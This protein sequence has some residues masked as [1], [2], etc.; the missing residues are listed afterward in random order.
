MSVTIQNI[1]IPCYLLSNKLPV[2]LVFGYLTLKIKKKN[3][4][5]LYLPNGTNE[6]QKIPL[7]S[8]IT[9]KIK[10]WVLGEKNY[11]FTIDITNFI[12]MLKNIDWIRADLGV[13]HFLH[14]IFLKVSQFLQFSFKMY[15]DYYYLYVQRCKSW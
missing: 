8:S 5:T 15:L 4:R 11:I 2:L 12:L 1:K 14:K 13:L 10:L 3:I 7:Q 9:G 6:N